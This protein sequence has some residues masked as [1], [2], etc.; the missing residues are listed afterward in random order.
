MTFFPRLLSIK[1]RI[2]AYRLAGRR[3]LFLYK[4]RI[5]SGKM[6]CLRFSETERKYN[7]RDKQQLRAFIAS[8]YNLIF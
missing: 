8:Q 2:T 4:D 5:T 6:V 3:N 7:E 1:H